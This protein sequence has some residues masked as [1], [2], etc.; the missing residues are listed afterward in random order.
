MSDTQPAAG[1]PPA[2]LVATRKLDFDE[3]AA[4]II[5]Y[6]LGT[7]DLSWVAPK[8]GVGERVEELTRGLRLQHVRCNPAGAIAPD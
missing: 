1:R 2:I 4:V 3:A 8:L 7:E 5:G 6:C